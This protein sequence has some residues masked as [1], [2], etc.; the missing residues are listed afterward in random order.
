M[1]QKIFVYGTLRTG[2]YNYDKYLDGKIIQSELAYVKGSLHQIKGVVYPAL[3]DGMHMI[4]GEIMELNNEDLVKELDALEGFVGEG[5]INNEYDKITTDIYDDVGNVIDQLP[6]YFYN[7]RNSKQ[8]NQLGSEITCCDYV[9]F[10]Y[11][12]G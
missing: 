5:N 12:K 10:I 8:L 9:K 11:Q 2:M 1:T 6:V 4:A 7:I 3:V